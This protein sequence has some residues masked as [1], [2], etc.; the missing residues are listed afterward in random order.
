M[1]VEHQY[2][3][4]FTMAAVSIQ[5]TQRRCAFRTPFGLF[6][7]NCLSNMRC[8]CHPWASIL[9]LMCA[10]ASGSAQSG[11]SGVS[12]D[13]MTSAAP[14]AVSTPLSANS[15]ARS[16]WFLQMHLTAASE[17][18]FG[19]AI[20]F[21]Y[22]RPDQPTALLNFSLGRHVGDSLFGWPA[23]LIAYGGIQYYAERGFQDD[24]VGATIY[25]KAYREYHL[26]K[27]RFPLRIGLG[28]GLSYASR[29]PIVEVEDFLPERSARLTNYLEWTVQ[30]SL[31]HLLGRRSGRFAPGIRDI[32]IGYSIF[33]RSTVFG[34]FGDKGGGVNYM[35]IGI[36]MV[37]D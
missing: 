14:S 5:D 11:E 24:A 34:L 3:D 32:H 23:R 20:A 22:E 21:Y 37:F 30:T 7:M 36:E 6:R 35:G 10:L 1:A 28:E 2:C 12:D 29:I 16:G 9:A 33:H 19:P 26:G 8:I 18:D 31:N 13:A 4:Y 27:R 25:I 17:S 15:T